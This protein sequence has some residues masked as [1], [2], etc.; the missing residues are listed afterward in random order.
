MSNTELINA[1]FDNEL[2]PS[3]KKMFEDRLARDTELQREFKFQEDVIEGIRE[4]RR[5]SLKAR[6][7]KIQVGGGAAGGS[8]WSA[9]KI[10][11]MIGLAAVVGFG[12]YYFYPENEPMVAE[13]PVLT[14]SQ[15]E[16]V[17]QPDNTID[18]STTEDITAAE[19]EEAREETPAATTE[20]PEVTSEEESAVEAEEESA[21]IR[22]E[23]K[24]PVVAPAFEDPEMQDSDVNLPE[25]DLDGKAVVTSDNLEV[26]ID[27]DSRRYDFHY[28]LEN[29]KLTLYGDFENDLYQILEF[30][31]DDMKAWF[32]SYDNNFYRLAPTKGRVEK[33][34][35]VTDGVLLQTLREASGN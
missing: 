8:S 18:N 17:V 20:E 5:Q 28:E 4:A 32:L 13:S 23:D 26:A 7:D 2:N 21:D 22:E 33:L 25:G 15:E 19:A 27:N 34:E 9:G 14:E 16:E 12:I 3:E 29:D 30:N 31:T 1:Y 24:N 6:L 10:A 35:Q 11:G